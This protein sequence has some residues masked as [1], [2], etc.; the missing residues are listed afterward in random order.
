MK[1]IYSLL[2]A[3]TIVL[4]ANA[5][6]TA[7][8]IF[9]KSN[10]AMSIADGVKGKVT[11]KM[12]GIG[13]TVNF[14]TNMQDT[15]IIDGED[16]CYINNEIAYDIDKKKK[17]ITISKDEDVSMALFIPFAI[18]TG[19]SKD[20]LADE[21][22][23]MGFKVEKTKEGYEIVTKKDGAKMVLLFDS[24]TFHIKSMK[25][26]KGIITVMSVTYANLAPFKNHAS[27]KFDKSKYSEYKFI[28]ERNKN[29]KKKK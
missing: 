11:V 13:E 7:I 29:E 21:Y 3:L 14:E 6:L 12:L 15:R 10:Q 16:V 19:A 18:T 4:S 2:L 28:D 23:K 8:Q 27:L 17:E 20:D 26:K 24:N 1:R 5:Q 22:K 25:M 9:K